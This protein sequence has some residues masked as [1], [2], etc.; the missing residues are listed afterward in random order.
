MKRE[1]RIVEI[2]YENIGALDQLMMKQKRT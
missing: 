1:R 2:R